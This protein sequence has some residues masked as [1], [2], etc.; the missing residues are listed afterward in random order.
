MQLVLWTGA[1]VTLLWFP[2]LTKVPAPT[3][4]QAFPSEC[5]K[6]WPRP[7]CVCM[8]VSGGRWERAS[9]C[10]PEAGPDHSGAAKYTSYTPVHQQ[11]RASCLGNIYLQPSDQFGNYCEHSPSIFLSNLSRP[12]TAEGHSHLS[13]GSDHP[14]LHWASDL[15]E[16][17]SSWSLSPW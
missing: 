2:N 10:A 9:L 4:V 13:R 14:K 5:V 3:P 6:I 12:G 15:P 1:S 7:V 11:M 17:F 8:C 16:V